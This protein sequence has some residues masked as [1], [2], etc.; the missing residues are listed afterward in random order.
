MSDSFSYV[1]FVFYWCEPPNRLSLYPS[2]TP[3]PPSHLPRSEEG[4]A[5]IFLI[6]NSPLKQYQSAKRWDIWPNRCVSNVCVST[7]F[8]F[9]FI[10]SSIFFFRFHFIWL[11][12]FLL[13]KTFFLLVTRRNLKNYIY[14]WGDTLVKFD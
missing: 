14:L 13:N 2:Q 6:D 7:G 10:Y 3:Q 8:M 11:S 4:E 12:F 1:K 9:L 5:I